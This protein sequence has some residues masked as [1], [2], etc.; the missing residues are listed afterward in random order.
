MLD[1]IFR[2]KILGY[3]IKILGY[4]MKSEIQIF[5]SFLIGSFSMFTAPIYVWNRRLLVGIPNFQKTYFTIFLSLSAWPF[6]MTVFTESKNSLAAF[7]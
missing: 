3:S 6:P 5:N 1:A 2:I 7:F 4:S